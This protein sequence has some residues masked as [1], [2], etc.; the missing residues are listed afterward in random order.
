M[1]RMD[2]IEDFVRA[3]DDNPEW[4]AA[5]RARLLPHELLDL[6]GQLADFARET[7]RRFEAIDKRFDK[8]D[9][10]FEAIGKR[11]DKHDKRFEAIDKRFDEHDKQF[12]A[13]G[14][15]FDEHD[16]RFE[17]IGRAIRRTRQ[18]LARI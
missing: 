17:A 8:H 11:F 5:V 4:R 9:K 7:A 10:Q 16:R 15:R 18:A 6:P 3:L 12:E 1:D 13:I 14:K 2:S